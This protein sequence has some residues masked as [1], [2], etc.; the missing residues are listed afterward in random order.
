SDNGGSEAVIFAAGSIRYD[1][2]LERNASYDH[3]ADFRSS[4]KHLKTVT[5]SVHFAV[6]SFDSLVTPGYP[7]K[8]NMPAPPN[9]THYSNARV[10]MLEAIK[11]AG[12]D[13]LALSN[14]FNL[15]LDQVGVLSTEEYTLQ[16]NLVPSG[17]GHQKNPE[18]VINGIH[19]SLF[20]YSME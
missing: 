5:D 16:T 7:T 3:V 14:P 18:F 19:V 20:S 17:I 12:F 1:E 10:E 15:D 13:A 11:Y 9:G 4:F 2:T 8:S 6:A